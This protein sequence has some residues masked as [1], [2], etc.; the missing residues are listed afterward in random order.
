[1]LTGYQSGDH[2]LIIERPSSLVT[3]GESICSLPMQPNIADGA[4]NAPVQLD[5]PERPRKK[6]RKVKLPPDE[7]VCASCGT[8]DSPEWR[9]GPMGPKTY[10]VP[11]RFKM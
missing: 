2:P 3:S 9:K 7:Y 10:H 6:N 11:F 4:T 1:M 8:T 5:G